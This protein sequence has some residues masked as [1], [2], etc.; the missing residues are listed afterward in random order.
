MPFGETMPADVERV[1]TAIVDSAIKVHRLLGPGL[2]ESV[3]AACLAQELRR[4]GFR[5]ER[6]VPVPIVYEGVTLDE[7]YR[8]DLLVDDLVVV[9][10]KAVQ[11]LHPVFAAQ[12]R[13]Y[14][15]LAN[16]R[17]GF[18]INFN[19]PLLK[20]GIRRIAN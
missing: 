18:L 4:R 2:L 7:G 3:Y 6:E 9:E 1:A 19:V 8:I 13:T 14:V 15:R 11:D 10:L 20:D 16:K 5:V 17:L 12:C